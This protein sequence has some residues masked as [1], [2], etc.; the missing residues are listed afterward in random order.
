MWNCVREELPVRYRS[1]LSSSLPSSFVVLELFD[2]ELLELEPCDVAP[3][4]DAVAT[5][6]RPTMRACALSVVPSRVFVDC[7]AL[8]SAWSGRVSGES[9]R[10]ARRP[11]S[12]VRDALDDDETGVRAD[13]DCATACAG[14]YGWS[15]A[16]G[17]MTSRL[18]SALM[19]VRPR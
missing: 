3:V 6:P 17:T 1:Q 8:S 18:A 12:D 11:S 9:A 4:E 16:S 13:S 5:P 10:A 14:R 2:V 7:R 15:A 19:S